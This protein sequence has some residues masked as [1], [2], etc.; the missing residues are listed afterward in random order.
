MF[1]ATLNYAPS[2]SNLV[3]PL[4]WTYLYGV[5]PYV[6]TNTQQITLLAAGVNWVSTGAQGGISNS[7]IVNGVTMDNNPWN[8]WYSVDWLAINVA[9]SLAA[10]VIN[11]SNNPQNPLYYNQA[12]INRL[13]TVAQSTVNNGI[14]FGLILSPATV[15]ATDFVTYTTENP[16]DYAIGK[17]AGLSCT[18]VPARGFS[19]ITINLTASNIP[20]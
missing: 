11:G 20:V 10:E 12:G 17:Y 13:Q 3:S 18:F 1:H 8:Y 4:E 14:S 6:L 5:T 19:S 7:L 2:A 15:N 16:G 9:Q